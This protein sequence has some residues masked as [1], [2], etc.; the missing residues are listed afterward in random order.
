MSA[1]LA[2]REVV[3]SFVTQRNTVVPHYI[4]GVDKSR[5]AFPLGVLGQIKGETS[6][7]WTAF[8]ARFRDQ[9]LLSF[10]TRWNQE[11]FELPVDY[12]PEG[13]VEIVNDSYLLKTGEIVHHRTLK[14]GDWQSGKETIYRE[15]PFFECFLDNL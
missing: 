11:F 12:L 6:M 5:F 9:R 14:P 15:K 8:V 13:I 3:K 1:D 7:G 4:A 10:G 2:Y